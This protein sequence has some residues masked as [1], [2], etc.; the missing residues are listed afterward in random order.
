M[1]IISIERFM[2]YTT[3]LKKTWTVISKQHVIWQETFKDSCSN[4]VL[5]SCNVFNFSG[6]APRWK[7]VERDSI[8]PCHTVLLPSH[9]Q[10]K[11]KHSKIQHRPCAEAHATYSKYNCYNKRPGARKEVTNELN[12]HVQ[13]ITVIGSNT[14]CT[15]HYRNIPSIHTAS[16]LNIGIRSVETIDD[17]HVC[18]IRIAPKGRDQAVPMHLGRTF[19]PFVPL[20]TVISALIH[21]W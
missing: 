8:R 15:L 20:V 16:K 14:H 17:G 12:T 10:L 7:Y 4:T 13:L 21:L 1:T 5:I 9:F 19:R 2:S 18:R 11:R 6:P 3:A